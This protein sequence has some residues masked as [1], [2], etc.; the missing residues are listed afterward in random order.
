[1]NAM[2]CAPRDVYI[3][4]ALFTP[5]ERAYLE[6]I[7]DL[8]RGIGLS[9]YLPHRDAGFGPA[10]DDRAQYYFGQDVHMLQNSACVVAVIDGADID[11]GTA[12][13]IGF[14]YASSKHI[15]GIREDVRDGELNPML[16]CTVSIARSFDELR[17]MLVNWKADQERR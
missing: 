15:V 9:T 5:A 6:R 8:C 2:E 10:K 11:S 7:D 16:A 4:G 13:E 12:W 3:S 14:S 1:M 17:R